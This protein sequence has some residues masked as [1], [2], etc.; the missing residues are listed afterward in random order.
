MSPIDIVPMAPS[1]CD[2]RF[3]DTLTVTTSV[4]TSVPNGHGI[5]YRNIG[6][7]SGTQRSMDGGT[8]P[9]GYFKPVSVNWSNINVHPL[10]MCACYVLASYMATVNR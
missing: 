2:E 4:P 5:G 10:T 6:Y 9:A 1:P 3:E 8:K 7:A